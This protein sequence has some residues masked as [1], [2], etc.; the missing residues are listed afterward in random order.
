MSPTT[1]LARCRNHADATLQGGDGPVDRAPESSPPR[2]W[3]DYNK[4]GVAGGYGKV[5]LAPADAVDLPIATGSPETLPTYKHAFGDG[6]VVLRDGMVVRLMDL[7]GA[8]Q[9][10]PRRGLLVRIG[11]SSG[12]S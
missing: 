7:D 4:W 8:D 3:V 6:R 11:C 9:N 2:V 5:Y 12:V 1:R 10:R